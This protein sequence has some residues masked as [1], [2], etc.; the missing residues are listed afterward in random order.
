M[1][2]MKKLTL[3]AVLLISTPTLHAISSRVGSAEDLGI[4]FALGQ[5]TG[6][7]A[8]YW[9]SSTTAIDASMGYHF[10]SNFDLQ[11]NYLWHSFSSFNVDRGRMPL[12]AG[13][14]ARVN[15]GNTSHLGMRMPIGLSY[16]FASDPVELFA[17]VAPVIRLITK[18]GFDMDG[19]VGIRV[20][21]NYL[22]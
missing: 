5:P 14:G 1:A 4:G 17:E 20:Y 22:K 19:R 15:L 8:K 9:L 12:Y 18:L 3:L 11:A 2:Q 13:L 16:L 7:T 21:L 6:P 10:N